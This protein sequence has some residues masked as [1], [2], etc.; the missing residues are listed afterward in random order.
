MSRLALAV[1]LF[2]ACVPGDWHASGEASARQPIVNG[3]REPGLP[4]SASQ[5][6]AVGWLQHGTSP[7]P[8]CGATLVSPRHVVTARHCTRD[9]EPADLAFG[10]GEQPDAPDGVYRAAAVF[11]HPFVDAAL[12]LLAEEVPPSVT[13]IAIHSDLD[14]LPAVGSPV[15][16]GGYGETRDI[17]RGGR[18][19]ATVYLEE[20][21]AFELV[22]DGRGEQGICYGDSGAGLLRVDGEGDAAV[23]AVEAY[24][25]DSCVDRDHL[26]RLDA[27]HDWIAPILDGDLPPTCAE[28]GD[29]RCVDNVAEVCRRGAVQRTDC[30][31]LGVECG[32]AESGLIG[33]PCAGVTDDVARCDGDVLERCANEVLQQTPCEATLGVGGCSF[34]TDGGAGRYRCTVEPRCR[35]ID[36]A[37]RCE[38][39]V[40]IN[41]RD[42]VTTRELCF[43]EGRAC[44][45]S[46][47]GASCV[48]PLS[49]APPEP[50]ELPG[51]S[52]PP[53][54]GCASTTSD[55]R[56]SL[57]A[58]LLIVAALARGG[59]RSSAPRGPRGC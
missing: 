55:P 54:A 50:A 57:V 53:G 11:S 59:P 56:T 28:V 24:G 14:E 38:G 35:D 18:W 4:L 27:I 13:P 16:I 17:E 36:A 58:L 7:V 47:G 34:E 10:I 44:I 1:L 30:T 42:D 46:A 29:G 2:S 19:F 23:L 22:V 6:A 25:D 8:F 31:S 15:T 37:G 48:D 41:C 51:G 52:A 40:A 39:D 45:V 9:F 3:S 49:P 20:V 21:R 5:A 32:R 26:V 12:I 33:C 43:A